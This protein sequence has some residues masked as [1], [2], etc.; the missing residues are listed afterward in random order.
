[1]TAAVNRRRGDPP[2]ILRAEVESI[3]RDVEALV[4]RVEGLLA[5]ADELQRRVVEAEY[6]SRRSRP[7]GLPC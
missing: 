4:Y 2:V 7:Q 5:A 6:R 3:A 1:M